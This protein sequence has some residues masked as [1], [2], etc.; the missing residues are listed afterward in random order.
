MTQILTYQQLKTFIIAHGLNWYYVESHI[1]Y[2]VYTITGYLI[3]ETSIFKSG[4]SP[5]G[6]DDAQNTIN[7]TDFENN[8]KSLSNLKPGNTVETRGFHVYNQ[9]L[10]KKSFKYNNVVGNST[11]EFSE[12]FNTDVYLSGGSYDVDGTI[13]D[14]DYIEFSV[15]D[16][17]NVLGYGAG[18]VVSKFLETEYI[19]SNTREG[20]VES[21]DAAFIPSSLYLTLTYHCAGPNTPKVVVRYLMRK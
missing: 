12:S 13:N 11:N 10:Y 19:T 17:D 3:F 18:F 2:T 8:Y 16:E 6:W 14:G 4:Y 20:T 15:T 7:R 9:D 5:V 1:K 21:L